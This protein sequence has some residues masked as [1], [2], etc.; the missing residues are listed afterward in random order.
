MT[1]VLLLG[2]INS[3]LDYQQLHEHSPA[4]KINHSAQLF[5]YIYSTL[6]SIKFPQSKHYQQ[7]HFTQR[8]HSK[9]YQPYPLQLI[10]TRTRYAFKHTLTMIAIVALFVINFLPP[11]VNAQ[12]NLG[13][14]ASDLKVDRKNDGTITQTAYPL[15]PSLSSS[16]HDIYMSQ[17]A[18]SAFCKRNQFSFAITVS[19]TTC[20]CSNQPVP[21]SNRVEDSRCN[22]PCA[23]YPPETCG[24]NVI[25]TDAS[26]ARNGGGTYANVMLIS[27][28]LSTLSSPFPSSAT[29]TSSEADSNN[30]NNNKKGQGI[31]L[32]PR[33]DTVS[34]SEVASTTGAIAGT[35]SPGPEV[36]NNSEEST[37]P[38]G[39]DEDGGEGDNEDSEDDTEDDDETETDDE[40]NDDSEDGSDS[41]ALDQPTP[42]TS[43]KALAEADPKSPST[44]IPVASTAVAVVCIVG[45]CAFIAYL[46]K[47]RKRE[48]VRAAWVDSV[49]GASPDPHNGK[50]SNVNKRNSRVQS[51]HTSFQQQHP[52]DDLESNNSDSQSEMME[53]SRSMSMAGTRRAS[54]LGPDTYSRAVRASILTPTT[55]RGTHE[56]LGMNYNHRFQDPMTY[57]YF[58]QGDFD[59]DDLLAGMPSSSNAY[60]PPLSRR[61]TQQRHQSNYGPFSAHHIQHQ[62]V[63]LAMDPSMAPVHPLAHPGFEDHPQHSMYQLGGQNIVNNK[64]E[65]E[66][67]FRDVPI[68]QVQTVSQMH[69]QPR[70]STAQR[71]SVHI[72]TRKHSI[73][74]SSNRHRSLVSEYRRPHSFATGSDDIKETEE[75][76][77]SFRTRILDE[78]DDES[79]RSTESDATSTLSKHSKVNPGKLS[80]GL[81]QHFKRLSLPYVQAIRQ[82]QQQHDRQQ[83]Q[84]QQYGLHQQQ[85][86]KVVPIS[87]KESQEYNSSENEIEGFQLI[88]GPAPSV[89]RRW[90]RS[91]LKNV[92]RGGG[93]NSQNKNQSQGGIGG[94]EG[95]DLEE[96]DLEGERVAVKQEHQ[97]VNTGSLASFRGL[98]DPSYPRLRVMNPD[99]LGTL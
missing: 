29:P 73:P 17:G 2:G 95:Y 6:I 18:C 16:F 8:Y 1:A 35:A 64:S 25:D 89:E 93:G 86:S 36:G 37:D 9:S 48:Q 83:Q 97:Q 34:P 20:Y 82:Q 10:R 88:P 40:E 22:V 45:I 60:A 46:A 24:S 54:A 32:V 56:N 14:F 33:L 38:S 41:D 4:H 80:G 49:F 27:S 74:P 92:V 28:T 30:N 69:P 76:P 66:N 53:R 85:Q 61:E 59:S 15:I 77:M 26:T 42:S 98:D 72:S 12:V 11:V 47:K 23:G 50:M 70:G 13:C 52:H 94:E 43:G 68:H 84:Q 7:H 55:V 19:G 51:R 5:L 63:H 39:Q 78:N 3:A 67:P 31:S 75:G 58:E 71:H 96:I 81:K 21:E 62:H 87:I 91:I 44:G 65:Y 57:E 99:D 90:S 79:E